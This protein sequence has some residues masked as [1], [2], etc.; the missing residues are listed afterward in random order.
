MVE[1][2][3][4]GIG[5]WEGVQT[6]GWMGRGEIW[7]EESRYGSRQYLELGQRGSKCR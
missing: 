6:E 1:I 2:S 3:S 5:K 4:E 7:G